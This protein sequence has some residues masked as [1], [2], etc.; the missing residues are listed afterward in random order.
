SRHVSDRLGVARSAKIVPPS[1][2]QDMRAV[3]YPET[4]IIIGAKDPENVGLAALPTA[5]CGLGA[6]RHHDARIDARRLVTTK[7]LEAVQFD[8]CVIKRVHKKV[9]DALSEDH[10]IPENA[11]AGLIGI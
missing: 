10:P 7:V 6:S 1:R 3:R 4:I 11:A 5:G 9:C 2:D 8:L